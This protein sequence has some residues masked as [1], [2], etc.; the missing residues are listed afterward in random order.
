MAM[1][2]S[3]NPWDV[4]V[5]QSSALA[6]S[7]LKRRQEE[8]LVVDIPKEESPSKKARPVVPEILPRIHRLHTPRRQHE[9]RRHPV[10]DRDWKRKK[11]ARQALVQSLKQTSPV[12]ADSLAECGLKEDNPL[13]Q[14]V[15]SS[16]PFDESSNRIAVQLIEKTPDLYDRS[17]EEAPEDD[18][19]TYGKFENGKYHLDL[20]LVLYVIL[21]EVDIEFVAHEKWLKE[22]DN[23]IADD[24]DACMNLDPRYRG[25]GLFQRRDKFLELSRWKDDEFS[26]GWHEA[27]KNNELEPPKYNSLDMQIAMS[28]AKAVQDKPLPED[29][30]KSP[31]SK[32]MLR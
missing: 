9:N 10:S 8:D 29:A 22:V 20:E 19:F 2:W 26:N 14:M 32:N 4:T 12:E 28:I 7:F 30:T 1:D 5:K 21:P 27:C 17:P 11:A 3:A 25:L 24:I 13:L 18:F 6:D 15:R 31:R 23:S 16:S